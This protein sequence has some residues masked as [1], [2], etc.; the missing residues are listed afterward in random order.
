VSEQWVAPSE[1]DMWA[2]DPDESN[3]RP[4]DDEINVKYGKRELRIVTE[5]NREQLPNFVEALKRPGWMELRPFYQRR[6]RWD[7]ARQSKL[8]ESFIMNIP[9]PPLFVYESDLAKY[10]VM[11]GQQRITAIRDFYT[12]KLELTGLEQWPELNGRIYDKLPSEIK[13]GIDR[14]SI[15]YF[16][17]L[18]ESA[19]T[20]EEEAL[21]RQQVFERLN[22]GGVKLSQQEIRNSI[23]HG[24][25]NTLL[26]ELV[27]HPAFRAAWGIPRYTS[28]EDTNPSDEILNIPMYAQMRDA[29]IVLRFFALRHAKNYKWGMAGFLDL[30]MVRTRKFSEEDIRGLSELFIKTIELASSIYGELLFRPWDGER[31]AWSQRPQVAFADAVMVGLSNHLDESGVL[32]NRRDQ[33][34]TY[35]K[36]LFEN[37]PPG[38][39][40]GQKNTKKDVQQ[41]I[42]LFDAM[43]TQ[44]MS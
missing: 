30:Y 44:V 12:N 13:K 21:L 19:V 20:S 39:F 11:D 9:V 40:T 4:D 10:E 37:N 24:K 35:T 34:I 27:K 41:R 16:V 42:D 32:A 29:E 8:I 26:L 33:I 25:F 22:T 2:R 43:L 23:Y 1:R 5:M 17:L 7:P 31:K 14:R 15:S 36:Q 3:R 38:T 28:E 6:P 18:K